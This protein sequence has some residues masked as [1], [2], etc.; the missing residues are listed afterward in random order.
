MRS[1][2]I[3][4]NQTIFASVCGII[5]S[6]MNFVVLDS[7]YTLSNEMYFIYLP[8]TLIYFCF[9]ALAIVEPT[10]ELLDLTEEE[11]NDHEY[12]QVETM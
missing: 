6:I 5:L 3:S 1:F 12:S 10:K 11:L 9:I 4:T 2:A 8:L 7:E